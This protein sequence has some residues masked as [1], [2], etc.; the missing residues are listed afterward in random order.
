MQL[1]RPVVPLLA[2]ALD[3]GPGAVGL[4]LAAFSLVPGLAAVR[5]G[6]AAERIGLERAMA[7]AGLTTVLAAG[8]YW[9]GGG[10]YAGLFGAQ[11]I[12]GLAFLFGWIAV[13]TYVTFV[14]RGAGA[15]RVVG[16]FSLFTGVGLA[17]GPVVGAWLFDRVAPAAAYGAYGL[18][19]AALWAA[20]RALPPGAGAAGG[21]L[22]AGR[23]VDGGDVVSEAAATAGAGAAA[24]QA[25]PADAG[26]GA[27]AVGALGR[28]PAVVLAIG[29]STVSLFVIG[30]RNTFYP[31]ALDRAGLD[32]VAIGLLMTL[33]GAASVMVRPLTEALAG[34]FGLAALVGWAAAAAALTM[35]ATP[36]TG[37]FAVL[38]GLAIGNGVA[39]G[40]HQ[41]L[42]ILLL[43]RHTGTRERATAFGLFNAVT[44]LAL[45]ASPIIYGALAG[46]LGLAG[47]FY[48]VGAGLSVAGAVALVPAARRVASGG[49]DA[50]FAPRNV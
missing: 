34:R 38:A 41:P 32:P 43:A 48:A 17:G 3:V 35:A 7:A 12:G 16:V 42:S 2:D 24:G 26:A 31:I 10:T 27:G 6:R 44:N 46:L 1:L 21:P 45:A 19:G 18:L 49:K 36:L 15:G 28:N 11:V 22:E 50:R 13:Q 14:A 20:A 47:A 30:A 5:L 33:A 37:R 8:L 4:A 39:A 29:F 23:P 9:A 40:F 25:A